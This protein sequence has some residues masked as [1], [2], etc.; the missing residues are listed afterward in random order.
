MTSRLR[1]VNYE[2]AKKITHVMFTVGLRLRRRYHAIPPARGPL[3]IVANHQSFLDPPLI[4]VSFFNR[5]L[6][7]VAREGLFRNAL[8]GPFIRSLNA[9]PIR[10]DGRSDATSIRRILTALDEG[11][12]VLLFPE[13]TRT[14]DGRVDAFK[15]GIA[16]LLKRAKCPVAPVAIAGAYEAWPRSQALPTLGGSVHVVV[17]RTIGHDA[18]VACGADA[19]LT[20]LRDEVVILQTE[21]QRWRDGD[22]RQS[23]EPSACDRRLSASGCGE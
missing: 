4:G 7:Y 15:R 21:A 17:G 6:R 11:A 16:L 12:A 1:G 20:R 9:I 19:A 14:V 18:L 13:G 23:G 8:F 3:L 10:E 5:P 2:C 22:M